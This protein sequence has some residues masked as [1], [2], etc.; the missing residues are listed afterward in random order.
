M[1]DIQES[2]KREPFDIFGKPNPGF[3]IYGRPI[4]PGADGYVPYEDGGPKQ[5]ESP[6]PQ[7]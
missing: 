3:N 5:W 7:R 4:S 6:N 2:A 1:S